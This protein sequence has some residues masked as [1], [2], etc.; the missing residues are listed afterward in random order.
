GQ[1]LASGW[2]DFRRDYGENSLD[3]LVEGLASRPG[4]RHGSTQ[5][6]RVE[7]FLPQDLMNVIL[8]RLIPRLFIYDR[9]AVG[10]DLATKDIGVGWR[11]CR[12]QPFYTDEYVAVPVGR[13]RRPHR[14]CD[15][16]AD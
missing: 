4:F 9:G 6:F 16:D 12:G 14:H 1:G 5:C 3:G 8:C 10:V 11:Q 7:R 13:R 2:R 15:S